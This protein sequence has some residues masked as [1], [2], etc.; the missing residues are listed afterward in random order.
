MWIKIWHPLLRQF[1]SLWYS[2][3]IWKY[4][5]RNALQENSNFWPQ[6]ILAVMFICVYTCIL[7]FCSSYVKKCI[8]TLVLLVLNTLKQKY[9]QGNNGKFRGNNNFEKARSPQKTRFFLFLSIHFFPSDKVN[10]MFEE[11]TFLELQFSLLV[12]KASD[13]VTGL[14]NN[15]YSTERWVLKGHWTNRCLCVLA[16]LLI[17]KSIF[18]FQ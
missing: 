15:W 4:S 9:F 8:W 3:N 18:A 10:Q 11:F 13:I 14:K 7:L 6:C 1:S 17:L 5:S 16:Q 12:I 2:Q